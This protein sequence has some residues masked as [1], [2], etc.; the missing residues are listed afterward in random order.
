[1][2]A[3]IDGDSPCYALAYAQEKD[4][5][6]KE[7]GDLFL[8]KAMDTMLET[9]ISEC[10][11]DDYKVFLSGKSNFRL[12]VDPLYKANRAGMKKPL[13]LQAA[14][15]YLE[16]V[17]NAIVSD[18]VEADDLVCIEQTALFNEEIESCIAGIDKDLLQ[19]EGCHYR[20]ALR[21]KPS[22]LRYVTK[23]EGLHNLYMQALEGD[24]IDNIMQWLNPETNTWQKCYGLGKV[25]AGKALEGC[26]TE[27]DFQRTCLEVY[28]T[29]K[30]KDNGETPSKE[31]FI[32]NMNLLYM[33][34]TMTDEWKCL[35]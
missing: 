3:L 34:R 14:R 5:E 12:E 28:S 24:K 27:K 9:I 26:V 7:N 11:A 15:D 21:G 17:H 22:V 32:V 6:V 8:Y 4:G 25:G 10:N 1:M 31:D 23:E 29:L 13:L 30:R 33:K 20:W 19:Q 16:I 2:M 35:V 18:G